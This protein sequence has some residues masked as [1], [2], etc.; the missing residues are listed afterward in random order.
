MPTDPNDPRN[1][2]AMPELP[3]GGEAIHI[4]TRQY[5]DDGT[6]AEAEEQ[7]V[8]HVIRMDSDVTGH[9]T[10]GTV[11]GQLPT[12]VVVQSQVADIIQKVKNPCMLCRNF[13]NEGFIE[14]FKRADHPAAPLELRSMMNEIR[15]QLLRT[16]NVEINARSSGQDG[17]LDVEHAIRQ[18]GICR[19]LSEMMSD[20]VFVHPVGGCP[21]TVITASDPDGLFVPKSNE[22]ERIGYAAYDK[23]LNAARG[24]VT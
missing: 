13:D 21:Q 12:A 18:M 24:K 20:L 4:T 8:S 3:N 6:P 19:A 14:M 15:M 17:D 7:T 10:P 11:E 9:M 5:T 1:N 23:L 16:G 22:A 2:V